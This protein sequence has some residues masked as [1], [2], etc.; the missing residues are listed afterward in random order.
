MHFPFPIAFCVAFLTSSWGCAGLLPRKTGK[1]V[2]S[3]PSNDLLGLMEIGVSLPRPRHQEK[4]TTDRPSSKSN[5]CPVRACIKMDTLRTITNILINFDVVIWCADRVRWQRQDRRNA[6]GRYSE[7]GTSH[8]VWRLKGD[9]PV[10]T[11]AST[12]LASVQG[13]RRGHL[14]RNSQES[15]NMGWRPQTS[16]H[17]RCQISSESCFGVSLPF[18]IDNTGSDHQQHQ[19]QQRL[20]E[21]WS[22]LTLY[23]ILTHPGW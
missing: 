10:R 21:L 18:I 19:Q 7:G 2:H 22:I 13:R 23:K 4:G 15:R 9:G 17:P 3:A 6:A 11:C 5:Q 1:G 20:S 12:Q 16:C 8:R 14:D